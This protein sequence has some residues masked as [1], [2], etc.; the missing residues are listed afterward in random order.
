MPADLTYGST[1][2]ENT[3]ACRTHVLSTELWNTFPQNMCT[4]LQYFTA[5]RLQNMK[6]TSALFKHKQAQAQLIYN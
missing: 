3:N 6:L 1:I 2:L 4:T 5:Q